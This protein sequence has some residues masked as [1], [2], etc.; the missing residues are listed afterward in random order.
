MTEIEGFDPQMILS[1]LTPDH[2][3]H[4]GEVIK[5]EIEYLNITQKEFA[6]RI[7][8]SATLVNL[9][10]KGNRPVNVEFALLTEAALNIPADLLLRMQARY[11]RWKTEQKPGFMEKLKSIKRFAAVL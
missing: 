2:V 3:T 11:D 7:G 5:D 10:L 8:L 9:V 6:A 4:P 1:N